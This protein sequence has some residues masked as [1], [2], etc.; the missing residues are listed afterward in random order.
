MSLL[1]DSL[2]D[3]YASAHWSPDGRTIVSSSRQLARWN[4]TSDDNSWTQRLLAPAT[5]KIA[6]RV[7]GA[8]LVR[9][10]ASFHAVLEHDDAPLANQPVSLVFRKPAN[11]VEGAATRDRAGFENLPRALVTDDHGAIALE[12]LEPGTYEL[13][14]FDQSRLLDIEVD[15]DERTLSF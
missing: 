10:R 9:A 14:C 7:E 12:D 6:W 15:D 1:Q 13:R 8:Q 5:T 2:I 4:A 3:P 11:L